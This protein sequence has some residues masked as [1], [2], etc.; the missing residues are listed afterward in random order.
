V[1][2]TKVLK[3]AMEELHGIKFGVKSV[4]EMEFVMEA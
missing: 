1:K 2:A 3:I 4:N